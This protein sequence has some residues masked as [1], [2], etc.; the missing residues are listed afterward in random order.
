MVSGQAT[1]T[2]HSGLRIALDGELMTEIR[3]DDSSWNGEIVSDSQRGGFLISLDQKSDSKT[4]L[5]R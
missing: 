3:I 4:S 1:Y 5:S 2:P